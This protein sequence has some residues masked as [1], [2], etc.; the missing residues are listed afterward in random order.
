MS[1][2]EAQYLQVVEAIH[3]K[4]VLATNVDFVFP[5]G[6]RFKDKSDYWT[7]VDSTNDTQ[8]EIETELIN[9]IWISYL[10]FEDDNRDQ[11]A[12]TK[13]ITF[14]LTL[15]NESTFDRYD[16]TATL[17]TF[18]RKMSVTD[19]AHDS[20]VFSLQGQFSGDDPIDLGDATFADSG[21]NRLAQ[22]DNTQREV[23]CDFVPDAI[24]SQTKFECQFRTTIC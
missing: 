23:N 15:F 12:F 6:V 4:C 16:E 10:R 8:K 21:T 22:I 14:G 5:N 20:A 24:G 1:L 17:S 2:S 9:A 13:T 18:E 19:S 3:D 11:E 7:F